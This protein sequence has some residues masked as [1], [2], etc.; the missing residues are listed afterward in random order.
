MMAVDKRNIFLEHI[1]DVLP[2]VSTS[3]QSD[4]SYPIRTNPARHA[5]Y[6]SRKLG[7]CN[8]Q[9]LQPRQVAA[10]RYK[11]GVYLEFSGKENYSLNVR[12]LENLSKKIRLLNVRQEGNVEKATIYVP[13]GE[14]AYFL[15]K[16]QAYADSILGE[17]NPKN[18]DLVRSIED[19]KLAIVESFWVGE[20][21]D[22]PAE[23][24]VWCEIWLRFEPGKM[25]EAEVEFVSSCADNQIEIKE[26]H[27][28]F[29]E[30]VVRMGK[31]NAEQLEK[32]IESCAYIAE[33]RKAPDSTGFF[34]DMN[35]QEQQEWVEELLSRTE[36]NPTNATICLLD[37]G[38]SVAHRLIKPAVEERYIQAV[39]SSW[40]TGDHSGHGTE[41]AGVALYFDLKKRLAGSERNVV[42]HLLESVK[43]LPPTG[44]NEPALYGA[45]T[46]QAVLLAEIENPTAE[47]TVCM[48]VTAPNYNTGDGSPTSWSGAIDNITSGVDGSGEKRLVLISAG[49]VNYDELTNSGFPEANRLH[50]VENP[51]QSWNALT[52]G[53]YTRD[54]TVDDT[55]YVGFSAVADQG[56]ISPYSSTSYLWDSKWPI[57]PEILLDGGNMVTNGQ[58][59]L[60]CPPLS[61]LTTD[62]HPLNYQFS[63]IWG[64]SSATA[65]AAWMTAQL[66]AEYPGI[67]PET[68][69]ALIVHSARWTSKM[70]SQY[71]VDD[72]KRKGR[73]DLLRICGYGIPNLDRAIQCHNNSVN[74]IVQG[75]LQPFI[76]HDGR[77]QMK[78]MH[79]H[80]IPWP[81]DL[82]RELG[83]VPV[84][85]RVTLSY[86]IEPGPGEKGWKDRYR[87]PSC[88][89]RFDVINSDE[90]VDDFKKRVNVRMRGEDRKDSGDGTS[91]SDRWFLGTANRDVGSIHSDFIRSTA[92]EL[93]NAKYIAVFP[94]V[95]WWRERHYLGKCNS[96]MRYSL[97]V[98]I[99]SPRV[100]I[101]LYTPIVTQ[102]SNMVPIEV[103]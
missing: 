101:D 52:V 46:E 99:S 103:N 77:A 2:Y 71:N 13:A 38:I 31:T 37:T 39:D 44:G 42:S 70:I 65:Q 72:K 1:N 92:V 84:E 49:N 66:F 40:N 59:Y 17:G 24:P 94:V 36:F 91:G 75:E 58:D 15:E 9:A 74:M 30:R 97:V 89:L 79:L 34:Y 50:G 3:K 85:M 12:S 19:V 25:E 63:T 100:D 68:V 4:K 23:E 88:G 14:E 11:Q 56:D 27:I 69:R 48:A 80:Q 73:R 54:I 87:Y 82:L 53:A 96:R 47:R 64:T 45:I 61:L 51:G 28:V 21:A 76:M 102:I 83:E 5:E 67:W 90:T 20:I 43:I 57:K 32:L 7:Q 93:C 10:I 18:N 16:V 98:S 78:E 33:I 81:A 41:M 35:F 95:G 60:S 86:F 26:G 55:A 29:P 62:R 6:I 8:Q 22:M